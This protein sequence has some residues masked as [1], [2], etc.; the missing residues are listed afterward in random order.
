MYPIW[1]FGTEEQKQRFL[2]RMAE[3]RPHRL[4]W[5]DRTGLRQRPELMRTK[6]TK[7]Q[8]GW[9][10]NG[11]KMW[12]TNAPIA[13]VA[14]VW[15]KVESD[16]ARSIRGFLVERDFKGFETPKMKDKMSLRAS[17]TGEIVLT[18]CF[19]PDENVLPAVEGLKGPLSCLTQAR[20]GI[21]WGAMGAALCC[22]GTALNY[23][24]ERIQFDRPIAS[25]QL[26]Q[27]KL[28]NMG[29]RIVAGHLLSHHLATLKDA[30]Q[31]NPIQVSLAKRENVA[32][33]L[34]I[35]RLS[36]S[37][38]GGNGVMS[39]YP[40]MRHAANLSVYTYEGTHE[41]HTLAIGRALTGLSAFS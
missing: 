33:A 23:S 3:W 35:A 41:V 14:I 5:V 22:Y 12:I 26:S 36:R 17:W 28:V 27:Q 34:D 10:L 24:T 29:S 32:A 25:F 15:A 21:S 2:P 6:A 37:L 1:A 38:L 4:L 30:G 20:Y 39:E 40:I 9:I 11:A 8:G 13:G 7:A 18:N 19:V 16:N 31:L